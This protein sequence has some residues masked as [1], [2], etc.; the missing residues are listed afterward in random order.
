M[1]FIIKNKNMH[2]CDHKEI[3]HNDIC[4]YRRNQ[5]LEVLN[6]LLH[7]EQKTKMGFHCSCI[8][9]FIILIPEINKFK[10]PD[11]VFKI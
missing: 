3:C 4:I 9:E 10:I 7:G 6:R 8:N 11:E 2:Y 1:M 5:S